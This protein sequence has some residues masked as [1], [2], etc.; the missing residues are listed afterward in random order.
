M[1]LIPLE[2]TAKLS[3]TFEKFVPCYD[4]NC[5]GNYIASNCFVNFA[6]N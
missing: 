2:L 1:A 6:V 4:A 3:M 5:L